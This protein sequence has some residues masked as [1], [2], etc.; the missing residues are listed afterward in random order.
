MN[1]RSCNCRRIPGCYLGGRTHSSMSLRPLGV[2]VLRQNLLPFEE[3][4]REQTRQ[5]VLGS[6]G[7][8]RAVEEAL[9]CPRV[10]HSELQRGNVDEAADHEV[11]LRSQ[12]NQNI[13]GAGAMSP[14]DAVRF[15]Q[16]QN[17]TAGMAIGILLLDQHDWRFLSV[18]RWEGESTLCFGQYLEDN[19]SPPFEK[20]STSGPQHDSQ[21]PPDGMPLPCRHRA[22]VAECD[23]TRLGTRFVED[24]VKIKLTLVPSR[25]AGDA[26]VMAPAHASIMHGFPAPQPARGLGC[27]DGS[28]SAVPS[29]LANFLIVARDAAML[30]GSARRSAST[31]G[32]LIQRLPTPWLHL[33]CH[34]HSRRK[35]QG[36]GTASTNRATEALPER[37]D[38]PSHQPTPAAHLP[39][40]R[41]LLKAAVEAALH[42][43]RARRACG[44]AAIRLH[45]ET[46][47]RSMFLSSSPAEDTWGWVTRSSPR[48]ERTGVRRALAP[49]PARPKRSSAEAQVRLIG[50]GGSGA[51][52]VCEPPARDQ[53]S[54]SLAMSTTPFEKT[55][56]DVR[57]AA[58]AQWMV[59]GRLQAVVSLVLRGRDSEPT[60]LQGLAACACFDR[61]ASVSDR[62]QSGGQA[63]TTTPPT[64]PMASRETSRRA[65]GGAAE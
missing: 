4:V 28:A 5:I 51:G 39:C 29:T 47:L 6:H 32:V 63:I 57:Q 20:P 30:E 14:G 45:T 33:V 21:S 65:R 53:L 48:S 1:M 12:S 17:H 37:E 56:I 16:L 27:L 59:C 25:D 52:A 46:L 15:A 54:R 24:S 10:C 35:I 3:A 8:T 18:T 43:S 13:G 7:D 34:L 55:S 22:T 62:P 58:T 38:F 61:P 49:T 40:S 36:A 11:D 19:N 60:W 50:R 26:G 41:K 31:T 2:V 23:A 9:H 42:A 44:L 64:A